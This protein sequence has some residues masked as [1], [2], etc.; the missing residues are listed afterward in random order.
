[1]S[2]IKRVIRKQARKRLQDIPLEIIEEK[3]RGIC[4]YLLTLIEFLENSPVY[5]IHT[6]KFIGLYAPLVDEVNWLENLKHWSGRMAFP[7]NREKVEGEMSFYSCPW[8]ELDESKQFGVLLKTPCEK[9]EEVEPSLLIV[10]GLAFTKLGD[11]LG[12]GKGYYDRYL[13]NFKGVTIG[14]A[15]NEQILEELP[16]DSHDRKLNFVVSE[17]GIFKE[18]KLLELNI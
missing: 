8:E 15:F 1:V 5:S 17:V 2:D 10:P 16:L 12:R 9:S 18:G 14:V 7:A 11:R 3:S 13:E 4:R 6:E